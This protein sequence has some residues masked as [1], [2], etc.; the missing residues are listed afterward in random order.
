MPHWLFPS[1]RVAPRRTRIV[2]AAVPLL[3][4]AP[5]LAQIPLVKLPAPPLPPP[6]PSYSFPAKE[7]LT[8]TVDWRVFPAGTTTLHLEQ[9]GSVEKV[10]A[11]ADT[12]GAINLI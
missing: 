6:V 8:Y 9:Q 3:L 4:A 2:R 5:L 10:T 1:P 11:T 12:L 7:T